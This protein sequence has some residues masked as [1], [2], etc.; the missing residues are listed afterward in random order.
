[1]RLKYPPVKLTNSDV[2]DVSL[3]VPHTLSQT[4][5]DPS[6]MLHKKRDLTHFTMRYTA[7]KSNRFIQVQFVIFINTTT[8]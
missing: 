8:Q 1:M 6:M 7:T 2:F 5:S 3:T 4:L